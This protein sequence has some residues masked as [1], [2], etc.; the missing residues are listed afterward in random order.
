ML[1]YMLRPSLIYPPSCAHAPALNQ[2]KC[3]SM[4][5]NIIYIANIPKKKGKKRMY[6]H[7]TIKFR[8]PVLN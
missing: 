4:S 7:I 3:Y 5:L 6:K 1:C 2:A 8:H